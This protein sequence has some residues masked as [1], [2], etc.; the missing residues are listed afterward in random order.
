[1]IVA[2]ELVGL[3]LVR[4]ALGRDREALR[5]AALLRLLLR[6][7]PQVRDGE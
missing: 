2:F 7:D 4:L 1:M 5:L 6:G 3:A